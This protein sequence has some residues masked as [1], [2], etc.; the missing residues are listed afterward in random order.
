MRT[1]ELEPLTQ[2][3]LAHMRANPSS[4]ILACRQSSKTEAVIRFALEKVKEEDSK[5]KLIVI[6][7]DKQRSVRE[8]QNA[9]IDR[10]R[11]DA[12]RGFGL[13]E[14]KNKTN[15]SLIQIVSANLNSLRGKT[16]NVVI[17][18]EVAFFQDTMQVISTG[19]PHTTNS[20][21][22]TSY[23]P[24]NKFFLEFA[25]KYPTLV[26]N[27]RDVPG[28]DYAWAEQMSKNISASQF[29]VEYENGRGQ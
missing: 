6:V 14:F 7:V 8:L 19:L 9:I 23:N 11:V 4:F 20:H 21:F 22:I 18:D 16:A 25:E 5:A 1:P 13:L 10:E 27:W 3:M 29:F 28:R 26:I 12:I 2:K 15:I 24:T 17:Y